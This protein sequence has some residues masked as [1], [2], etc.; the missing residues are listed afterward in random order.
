MRRILYTLILISTLAFQPDLLAQLNNVG[1]EFS[2]RWQG[3]ITLPNKNLVLIFNI[4]KNQTGVYSATLDV[5]EQGAKDILADKVTA[6][7]DSI[8]IKYR[9]LIASF[10]GVLVPDSNMI[11]GEWKQSGKSFPLV[12]RKN[13]K[14]F[15]IKREQDPVPPFDYHEEEVT[16]QNTNAGITLAGTLTYP[17]TGTKFP[18]VVLITGSGKQNRNEEVFGHRPFLIIADYLTQFGIAVLR[19]DDRGAGKS[20]GN[21]AESTSADFATDVEAEVNY[22]K[23]RKEIDAGQI[24]LIG[25]SEGGIIAPMVAN[26]DKSIAFLVLL[27]APG[28]SGDK[29]LAKQTED[30]GKVAGTDSS[31]LA[32]S[33]AFNKKVYHFIKTEKDSATAYEKLLD[34]YLKYYESVGQNRVNTEDVANQVKALQTKWLKY[35]L[36]YDPQPALKKIKCPV[37]ALNGEKDLQ[38]SAKDNLPT[39]K[40]ALTEAGNKNFKVLEVKGVNHLFQTA[41]TGSPSEYA[42]IGETI[43]Y[44][45]LNT[46]GE[47]IK[48]VVKK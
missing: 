12:L 25:H 42:G 40:R 19:V 34:G 23:T 48:G 13:D 10:L 44:D 4:S 2:G 11:K 41:T 15:V 6:H 17:K 22:L 47:W 39:I 20:T 38:V 27:A 7:K 5:P 37:L 46:V 8:E 31:I 16:I 33:V 21:F 43:S 29:I 30:L 18:A 9:S 32:A 35:F 45:V 26:N 28:V 24:G 14:E 3:E 36:S 1:S